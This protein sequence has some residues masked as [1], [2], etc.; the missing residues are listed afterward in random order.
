MSQKTLIVGLSVLMSVT[1]AAVPQS[2][3]ALPN[4]AGVSKVMIILEENH[5]L[6]QATGTDPTTGQFSMPYLMGQLN[7]VGGAYLTNYFA[8]T[9]P[10]NPNY[11][12]LTSG[13]VPATKDCS[14]SSCPARDPL[15]GQLVPSVFGQTIES[16]N[17]AASYQESMPS[18]CQASNAS[19]YV[20]RHNPWPYYYLYTYSDGMSE[21]SMC[22]Q[23]DVPVD[24]SG[25]SLPLTDLPNVS[26]VTP[27]LLHDAH[28]GTLLDADNWLASFLPAVMTSPD[29]TDGSLAILVTFDEAGTKCGCKNN[30]LMGALH[31]GGL[32]GGPIVGN[33]VTHLSTYNTLLAVGTGTG[34]GPLMQA[35]GL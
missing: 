6:A 3:Q 5:S 26:F 28:Q 34:T 29:Y 23:F 21:Q 8:V 19:P 9:H 7:S 27:N 16:G 2:A 22:G 11:I 32:A 33:K 13:V 15:T 10:S 24:A 18:N 12:A 17:T 1:S 4:T 30:V 20:V 35:F 14:P 31:Q 25:T